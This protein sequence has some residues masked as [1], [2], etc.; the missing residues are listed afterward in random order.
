[1]TRGLSAGMISAAQATVVRPL[2]LVSIQ[3]TASVLY[4]CSANKNYSWSAQTWLGNGQLYDIQGLEEVMEVQANGFSIELAGADSTLVSLSLG[5]LNQ[6]YIGTVYLALL[7]GSDAIIS[8]PEQIATGFL[9]YA[10]IAENGENS[11]IVFYYETDFLRVQRVQE[12]RY[13]HMS[14][15]ALFPGD[16]GFWWAHGAEDWSG[17][18][19]KSARRPLPIRKRKQ[20][21]H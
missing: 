6:S 21:R 7:D 18:W 11:R 14:Q 16:F 19:G 15:Q 20:G 1:M 12:F 5:S 4:L 13:T 3:Y 17:F 8:D 9:D 2:F 10:E